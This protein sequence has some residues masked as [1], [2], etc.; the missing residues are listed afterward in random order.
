MGRRME[1]APDM[2]QTHLDDIYVRK[3]VLEE[4][5]P[6]ELRLNFNELKLYI[7]PEAELPFQTEAKRRAKW[8][9]IQAQT[10]SRQ[11]EYDGEIIHLP[12]KRFAAP[13]IQVTQNMS[14][15]NE[16]NCSYCTKL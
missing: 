5:F 3:E 6:I 13:S 4:W 11:L 14:Y 7:E 9:S 10:G 16:Q 15:A 12:Y 2:V 8:Q 1:L